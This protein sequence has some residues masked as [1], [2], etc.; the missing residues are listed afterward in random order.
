MLN[1]NVVYILF[2]VILLHLSRACSLTPS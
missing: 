2:N 1:D